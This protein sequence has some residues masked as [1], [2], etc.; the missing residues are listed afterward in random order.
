MQLLGRNGC[1]LIRTGALAANYESTVPHARTSAVPS[2][3][4]SGSAASSLLALVWGTGGWATQSSTH[5]AKAAHGLSYQH[6]ELPEGPWSTHIVKIERTNHSFEV[7][8]TLA[9][10]ATFGL[11]T[12]SDQ[13]RM[14]PSDIGRPVAGLNGDFFR[15]RE[16][17]LGDPKGL[18]IVRGELVSA[19]CDWTCFWI[20]AKGNPQMTNVTARFEVTWPNGDRTPFGLNEDRP[21]NGAVL[22]TSAVGSSTQTS[23]GRELILERDGTNNWLPLRAGVV[24]SARVRQAVDAGN[25]PIAND[26]MVLSFGRVL[27]AQFAASRAQFCR[28]RPPPCPAS[29]ALQ[30]PSAEAL[31]SSAMARSWTAATHA[32]AIP[33]RR[34]AGTTTSSFSSKSTAGSE[35]SP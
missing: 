18:Q 8:S 17:Y 22:Y 9:R 5:S 12:L 33:A 32:S 21:R 20:D 1:S 16:P 24:Y 34:W 14:L 35:D 23:G 25:S 2:A 11:A 29:R 10:G 13:I 30:P 26:T 3:T 28:F 15:R 6:E 19:P 7:H 4:C 27:A 31:P